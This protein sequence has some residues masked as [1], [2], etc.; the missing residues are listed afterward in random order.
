MQIPGRN[1]RH[2]SLI[3]A[4][5]LGCAAGVA[6]LPAHAY[7][8]WSLNGQTG[9]D[10]NPGRVEEG[11]KGSA[12]LYGGGTL[13]IDESRPRLDAKVGANVGYQDYLEGGYSGQVIGSASVDLRYALIP[14]VLFW[15]LDD[16]FGQGTANVLAPASPA[17]RIQVNTFTTGPTLVLPINSVTRVRANALFGVDSYSGN[18]LPDDT[19]YSGGLALVRQLTPLTDVSLNADYL[20]V[21]YGSYAGYESTTGNS[22]T[23]PDLA[24]L[25]DYQRESVYARYEANNR[26]TIWNIDVGAARVSQAGQSFSSPL[27]RGSWDHK[28]SAYWRVNFAAAREYTDGAEQ[29]G[30]AVDHSGI[31]LPSAPPS[32]VLYTTQTLP[33]TNQ[34]LRSDNARGGVQWQATR[35]SFTAGVTVARDRFLIASNSD[36]NRTGV[37]AGFMRR[38][39][40]YSDIH[41]G[42]SYQSRQFIGVGE[43]DK[44]TYL[45]ANYS[46]QFEPSFQLYAGYNYEKRV[47]TANFSYTDNRVV[48]GLRYA[49]VHHTARPVS[50]S[51][52]PR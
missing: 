50:G 37:D 23:Q 32:G 12:T 30:T 24:S 25:G 22:P 16:H 33:L 27:V 49:P 10:T 9:Y 18:A 13:T 7:V 20:K 15:S 41:L 2:A 8:D 1:R 34:P 48:I 17:N 51:E 28:V 43:S 35:T 29:F 11:A 3:R 47:S 39:T 6:A 19:R 42:A 26:R 5:I 40:P 52:P 31:P 46:W 14:Q 21:K 36:D 4:A 45:N 38:L 44:T